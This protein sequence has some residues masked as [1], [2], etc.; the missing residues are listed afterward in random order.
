MK[1]WMFIC[2]DIAGLITI[3]L[4][5]KVFFIM[6][7][8]KR[9]NK[10]WCNIV[11]DI[12]FISLG[13]I[14]NIFK[15]NQILYA[16]TIFLLY[17]VYSF[18]YKMRPF[19]RLYSTLLCY[20]IC[21]ISEMAMGL[22]ISTITGLTVKESLLNMGYYVLNSIVSKLILYV[23]IKIIS[24]YIVCKTKYMP[25]IAM[26]AFIFLPTTSFAILYFLSEYVY[27]NNSS[28]IQLITFI[29]SVLLIISNIVVFFILDYIAKQKDKEKNIETKAKLLEYERQYYNDLYEKQVIS[30][31]I[32]HDIKNMFFAFK[33]VLKDDP[34]KATEEL[35][36]ISTKIRDVSMMKITGNVGID[37]LL[38][39]KFAVA[40]NNNINIDIQCM[41]SLIYNIDIVD[42]CVIIGNLLDNSIEACLK[43]EKNVDR[44]IKIIIKQ[45]MNFLRIQ[46]SNSFIE[47]LYNN[48][49]SK[50]DKEHHGFGLQNVKELIDKYNGY[51]TILKEENVYTTIVGIKESND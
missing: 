24:Y 34:I 5:F 31:K 4:I 11:F 14:I 3:I 13:A 17:F 6:F 22:L 48:R 20:I 30:D 9:W 19:T 21:I 38:N 51:F 42:L 12:L 35:E 49:T 1:N 29:L 26:L 7:G 32:T 44:F 45:E 33:E 47:D 39:H 10:Y 46:I 15:S 36:E 25:K 27:N 50:K 16:I 8:E 28:R 40:K 41:I 23:F 43:I 2:A 18:M 37:S